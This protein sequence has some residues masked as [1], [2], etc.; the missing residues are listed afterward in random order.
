[1]EAISRPLSFNIEALAN[2]ALVDDPVDSPSFIASS[3]LA[4][5]SSTDNAMELAGNSGG[6]LFDNCEGGIGH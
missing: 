6:K 4:L 3:G 2:P 1:M 5:D